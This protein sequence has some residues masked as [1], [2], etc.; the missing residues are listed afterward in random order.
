M[1]VTR[2]SITPLVSMKRSPHPPREGE[3]KE[4]EDEILNLINSLSS[5]PAY[6]SYVCVRVPL[7]PRVDRSAGLTTTGPR[8]RQLEP[9]EAAASKLASMMARLPGVHGSGLSEGPG[10][11]AMGAVVALVDPASAEVGGG[12]NSYV[13]CAS[14]SCPPRLFRFIS[15]P[16]LAVALALVSRTIRRKSHR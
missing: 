2:P 14:C 6:P 10:S 13:S 3:D 4:N 8:S 1:L 12:G 15:P 7:H 11:A 5:F 16:R 9:P